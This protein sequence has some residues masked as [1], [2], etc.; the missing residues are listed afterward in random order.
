MLYQN[1]FEDKDIEKY[2]CFFM[3]IIKITRPELLETDDKTT[4]LNIYRKLVASKAIGKECYI[5]NI[6]SVTAML[7]PK[8]MY[9]GDKTPDYIPNEDELVIEK[10]TRPKYVHFVTL[11]YD[12]IKGGSYTKKLGNCVSRRIFKKV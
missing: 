10:W 8:I 12:P 1:D 5:N 6:Y 11:D 9:I 3:S 2:G 4:I 7:N